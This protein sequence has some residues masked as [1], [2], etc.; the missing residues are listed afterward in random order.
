MEPWEA[1]TF[2]EVVKAAEPGKHTEKWGF[3]KIKG[4]NIVEE[5]TGEKFEEMVHSSQRNR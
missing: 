2:K 3:R 4:E 1:S 5:K